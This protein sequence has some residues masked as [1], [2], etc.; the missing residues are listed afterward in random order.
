MV[1]GVVL[2]R[3][4]QRREHA[5]AG[6]DVE[7]DRLPIDAAEMRR[8]PRQRRVDRLEAIVKPELRGDGEVPPDAER[9]PK[10]RVLGDREV[11]DAGKLRRIVVAHA[12][13]S[14]EVLGVVEEQGPS[15][16][17]P[18]AEERRVEEPDLERE[19][20]LGEAERERRAEGDARARQV[21]LGNV[22]PRVGCE[23]PSLSLRIRVLG[24]PHP[25]VVD[26]DRVAL[27]DLDD[28]ND[29]PASRS[30]LQREDDV[31]EEAR[32]QQAVA[33]E[34][35]PRVVDVEG[36]ADLERHVAQHDPR[37]GLRVSTNLDAL[38]GVSDGA[39]GLLGPLDGG[40]GGA[41]SGAG[42]RAAGG[43][44]GGIG[45][46]G[47]VGGRP[48]SAGAPGVGRGGRRLAVGRRGRGLFTGGRRR[49]G[50]LR[51]LRWRRGRGRLRLFRLR[52]GRRIRLRLDRDRD[53][54]DGDGERGR[55]RAHPP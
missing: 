20:I 40:L 27:D 9:P 42:G 45:R 23:G 24:E 39:L 54:R 2:Q 17:P 43:F 50:L 13:V 41:L 55:D 12:V 32:T 14:E 52:L 51:F 25:E 47:S 5:V 33:G 30:L 34:L 10:A 1:A 38:E 44:F 19:L 31:A 11:L 21:G 8:G 3:R 7:V 29:E 18:A 26:D 37:T 46:V 28:E 4:S 16:H 36:I 15:G 53:E 35:D 22:E 6:Q 49:L 48:R